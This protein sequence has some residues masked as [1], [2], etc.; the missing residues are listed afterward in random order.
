MY[1]TVRPN[2]RGLKNVAV[3]G[4]FID[5]RGSQRLLCDHMTRLGA[6][7]LYLRNTH[8]SA[9]QPAVDLKK[10]CAQS[11]VHIEV[12]GLWEPLKSINKSAIA[13]FLA[14]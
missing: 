10:I 7:F 13:P 4:L 14:Q 12:F 5:F 3:M 2:K 11:F 8:K 6:N 9:K 1:S